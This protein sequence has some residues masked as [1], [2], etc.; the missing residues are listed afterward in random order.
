[1][2]AKVQV[3][4]RSAEFERKALRKMELHKLTS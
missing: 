2:L 1:M 3:T 4:E